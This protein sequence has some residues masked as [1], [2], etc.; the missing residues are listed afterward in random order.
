MPA[1]GLEVLFDVRLAEPYLQAGR[2]SENSTREGLLQAAGLSQWL[3][4]A[5]WVAPFHE[6][7]LHMFG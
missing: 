3:T 4:A 7:S 1:E 6:L 2:A 5:V